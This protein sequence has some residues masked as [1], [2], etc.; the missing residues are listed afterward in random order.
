MAAYTVVVKVQGAINGLKNAFMGL[1]TIMSAN[2]VAFWAAAIAA[3]VV[4]IIWAW[5]NVDWF[6]D[7][8]TTAWDA[9]TTAFTWAWESVLKPV[10]EGIGAVAVWLWESV[11]QPVIGF[12]VSA[13]KAMVDVMAL[14]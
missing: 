9:I 10:F 2:P 3:L 14:E 12:I 11:L 1:N 7:A 13:W 5:N 8:V 4:G 6:R